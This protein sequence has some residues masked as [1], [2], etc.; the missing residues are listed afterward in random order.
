MV[1]GAGGWIGDTAH[2]RS[3]V[4]RDVEHFVQTVTSSDQAAKEMVRVAW[5][6]L[7]PAQETR[8]RSTMLSIVE[9]PKFANHLVQFLKAAGATGK[10]SG[11]DIK[12]ATF[13]T[14]LA[15]QQAGLQRISPEYSVRLLRHTLAM[16][17]ALSDSACT[18]LLD[19]NT[20][21]QDKSQVSITYLKSIPVAQLIDYME[22][23][24]QAALAELN[25]T[26]APR[27]ISSENARLAQQAFETQLKQRLQKDSH[28]MALL[29]RLYKRR[30]GRE[31]CLG[32]AVLNETALALPE[33]HRARQVQKVL[34]GGR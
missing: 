21:P 34:G 25:G 4:E 12:E 8:V 20:S 11:D 5:G 13:Q 19:R 14:T 33:P 30:D 18:K 6:Q 23:V 9:R 17:N 22:M 28:R 32:L 31:A 2:A 15:L 10:L 1:V 7:T 3:A 27:V 29:Q 24:E 16:M 26:P